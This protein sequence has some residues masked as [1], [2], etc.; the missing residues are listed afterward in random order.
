MSWQFPQ[1]NIY[2]VLVL[3]LALIMYTVHSS[4]PKTLGDS[5]NNS[6]IG[7]TLKFNDSN[8]RISGVNK[9][10]NKVDD[11]NYL[12]ACLF[13]ENPGEPDSLSYKLYNGT[14]SIFNS[15]LKS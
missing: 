15:L 7:K 4:Q 9:F 1:Y 6:S 13:F 8:T 14:A 5:I 3:H 2:L 11:N 12:A 10:E